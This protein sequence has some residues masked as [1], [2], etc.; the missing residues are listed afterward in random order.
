MKT[1]KLKD[2][3]CVAHIAKRKRVSLGVASTIFKCMSGARQREMR[4]HYEGMSN[5]TLTSMGA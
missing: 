3:L 5:D 2:R 1:R 4:K